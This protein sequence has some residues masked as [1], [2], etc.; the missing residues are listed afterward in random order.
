VTGP[1]DEG[2][3]EQDWFVDLTYPPSG[4][5][6]KKPPLRGSRGDAMFR[7]LVEEIELWHGGD[8]RGYTTIE[9]K[10]HR[11]HWPVLGEVFANWLRLRAQDGGEPM[12]GAMEI[13]RLRANLNARCLGLGQRH[14]ICH[15]VGWHNGNIYVD[16]ADEHWR[17]VE[18]V[19][20]KEHTIQRWQVVDRPPVRFLRTSGMRSMPAPAPG[21]TI[22]DLRRWINVKS[23]AHFRLTLAWVLNCFRDRGPFPILNVRGEQG[24]GKSTLTR[25]LTRLTD[26]Q[27]ADLRSPPKEERD[28]WVATQH[29]RVLAYDNLSSVSA[30]LADAFCRIA[31]GGSYATRT[32][33]TNADETI[34]RACRPVMVNAI[35][36][37]V[38]R[39]DLA[40]RALMVEGKRL[41]GGRRR[42]EEE[43]W[44]DFAQEEP[45]LLGAIFDVLSFALGN[46]HATAVPA[47]V[48]MADCARWAEAPAPSLNWRPGELSVWWQQ[49]RV[50]VDWAI[51]EGD[52]V[53][54]TLVAFLDG[55]GDGWEGSTG[56]LLTRLEERIAGKVRRPK[57]WP[58][59]VHSLRSALDRLR[60]PLRTVGWTFDRDKGTR[61]ARSLL[62]TRN[63]AVSED[64]A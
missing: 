33:T 27:E 22:D 63:E 35:V 40:D 37:L 50:S 47:N 57:H 56:E 41:T 34:L 55:Q 14:D 1:T 30:A 4:H 10:G 39:P 51:I 8:G 38:R 42:T 2:G 6:Q 32:L 7:K 20:A 28:L 61:G 36:D 58:D 46:Y 21:G 16:L 12:L 59:N 31:T 45:L 13:E 25:L 3:Q 54:A 5:R 44:A 23:E 19:P 49:N 64:Q 11:E 24:S 53:G 52:V 62:F 43:F 15:R 9:T 29:A 17:A 48:R 60:G 26:P 18:I